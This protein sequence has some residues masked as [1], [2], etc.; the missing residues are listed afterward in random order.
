MR[1]VE[2]KEETFIGEGVEVSSEVALKVANSFFCWICG[3]TVP[4]FPEAFIF[5]VSETIF[6]ADRF[7]LDNR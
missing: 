4:F 5:M 6:R 7:D 3:T 2:L 1:R